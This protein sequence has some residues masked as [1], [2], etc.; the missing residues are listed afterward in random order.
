V[1]IDKKR[2]NLM[3]KLAV[4]ILSAAFLSTALS[5][6]TSVGSLRRRHEPQPCRARHARLQPNHPGGRPHR[7]RLHVRG[8][9]GR[10]EAWRTGRESGVAG[11]GSRPPM[12]GQGGHSCSSHANAPLTTNTTIPAPSHRVEWPWQPRTHPAEG[13]VAGPAPPLRR[14]MLSSI[15]TAAR[16]KRHGHP[17]WKSLAGAHG[18]NRPARGA[19]LEN[20][21]SL[22]LIPPGAPPGKSR[23]GLPYGEG[24]ARAGR[25]AAQP[26]SLRLETRHAV[27]HRV[28]LPQLGPRKISAAA[29]CIHRCRAWTGLGSAGGEES[30]RSRRRA[31]IYRRRRWAGQ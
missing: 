29:R 23:G 17:W 2:P 5:M 8:G 24:Q 26:H 12:E 1:Q 3:P 10:S 27:N 11:K 19:G 14:A 31:W 28:S 13:L 7:S 18:E 30:E 22:P 4:A 9:A 16:N 21:S 25:P 20:R 6:S 15:S